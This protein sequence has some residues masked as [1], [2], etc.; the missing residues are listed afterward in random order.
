MRQMCLRK[1]KRLLLS[2]FLCFGCAAM[3]SP[4]IAMMPQAP[5]HPALSHPELMSEDDR[6][7]LAEFYRKYEIYLKK[8]EAW[9]KAFGG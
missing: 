8:L 2:C 4:A 1:S 6:A 3:Q 5:T 9:K 7:K